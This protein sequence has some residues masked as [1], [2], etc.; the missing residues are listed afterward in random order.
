[1]IKILTALLLISTPAYS[2]TGQGEMG[3]VLYTSVFT[4]EYEKLKE[5]CNDY[6]WVMNCDR[7]LERFDEHN[8]PIPQ[9][10]DVFDGAIIIE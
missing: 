1:M 7:A 5:F 3:A 10:I 8:E 6:Q 9:E 2:A 4:M